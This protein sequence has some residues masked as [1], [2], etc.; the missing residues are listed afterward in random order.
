MRSIPV[1]TSRLGVLRCAVQPE[2]K[3]SAFDTQEVKK[4]KEGN[5]IHTVG[6][7]VRQGEA[8]QFCLTRRPTAR[9]RGGGASTRAGR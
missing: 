2:A 9:G 3:I 5:A 8:A 6:V 7:M 4:D 1:D